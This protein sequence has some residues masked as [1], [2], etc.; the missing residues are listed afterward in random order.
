[1]PVCGGRSHTVLVAVGA[2]VPLYCLSV[3]VQLEGSSCPLFPVIMNHV[4]LGVIFVT[5]GRAR[6]RLKP[7]DRRRLRGKVTCTSPW[8]QVAKAFQRGRLRY[9]S[10]Q[11]SVIVS[12][13]PLSLSTE[14]A[15]SASIPG[16]VDILGPGCP[17]GLC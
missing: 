12:E 1:M 5:P 4:D 14:G 13:S 15:P 2:W 11:V 6:V 10:R 17:T 16:D 3:G 7:T 9:R 8:V